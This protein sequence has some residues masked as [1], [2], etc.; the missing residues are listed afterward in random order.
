MLRSKTFR[1]ILVFLFQ[2]LLLLPFFLLLILRVL[3]VAYFFLSL[4][5][6]FHH[7]LNSFKWIVEGDF[8]DFL[9][10]GKEEAMFVGE[11]ISIGNFTVCAVAV[12]VRYIALPHELLEL[13]NIAS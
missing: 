4:L 6:F 7:V 2:L 5:F 9:G 12:W 1:F 3:L 11:I 8:V 13:S 10:G